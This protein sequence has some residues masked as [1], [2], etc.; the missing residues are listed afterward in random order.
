MARTHDL[1]VA[2]R[3]IAH[4][5][6]VVFAITLGVASM[7]ILVFLVNPLCAV[8]TFASL[9][10]YVSSTRLARAAPRRRTS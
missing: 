3:W 4:A 5:Q 9:I 8:L 6:A 7:A 2:D 1:H 10:G